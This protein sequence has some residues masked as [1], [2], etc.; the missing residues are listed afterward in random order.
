[1]HNPKE[2]RH[3]HPQLKCL[4]SGAVD[5]GLWPGF[6]RGPLHFR[7]CGKLAKRGLG[8]REPLVFKAFMSAEYFANPRRGWQSGQVIQL[9]LG[10]RRTS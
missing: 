6:A 9:S 3:N 4:S 7:V 8:S 2:L 1:M 10:G 5:T